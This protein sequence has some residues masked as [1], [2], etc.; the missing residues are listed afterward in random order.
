MGFSSFVDMQ[1]PLSVSRM[2]LSSFVDMQLP[3]SAAEGKMRSVMAMLHV[4]L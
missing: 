4:S 3:L 2:G 1:L